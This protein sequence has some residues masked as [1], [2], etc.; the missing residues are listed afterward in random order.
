MLYFSCVLPVGFAHFVLWQTLRASFMYLRGIELLFV[1]VDIFI[2]VILLLLT[3]NV[4]ELQRK[5]FI[6]V[7]RYNL[8]VDQWHALRSDYLLLG[9]SAVQFGKALVFTCLDHHGVVLFLSSGWGL[10]LLQDLLSCVYCF[11]VCK[12]LHLVPQW[13]NACFTYIKLIVILQILLLEIVWTRLSKYLDVSNSL[14]L[15]L[16][17][18]FEQIVGTINDDVRLVARLVRVAGRS[19]SVLVGCVG[20]MLHNMIKTIDFNFL[21]TWLVTKR[22][23]SLSKNTFLFLL[24]YWGHF[25]IFKSSS[26]VLG[27]LFHRTDVSIPFSHACE[28]HRAQLKIFVIRCLSNL[29][30]KLFLQFINH[31]TKTDYLAL[32]Q[33]L[34]CITAFFCAS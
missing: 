7:A 28:L 26:L 4:I 29:L 12:T 21:N 1:L 10:G 30:S 23:I 8:F 25:S 6:C 19:L 20:Y 17:S 2:Q 9:C 5:F 24:C 31:L 16:Y 32:V 11:P 13:L 33:L 22:S 34:Y 27:N 3:V 15:T 14:F 18:C